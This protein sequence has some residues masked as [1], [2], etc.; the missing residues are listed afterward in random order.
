LARELL[1]RVFILCRGRELG[2][3]RLE[4]LALPC[5]GEALGLLRLSRGADGDANRER[6]DGKDDQRNRATHQP[7]LAG[8]GS[9]ARALAHRG[10]K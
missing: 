10:E 4:V 1:D 9:G 6:A 5:V 7:P 3:H 2:M 8:I